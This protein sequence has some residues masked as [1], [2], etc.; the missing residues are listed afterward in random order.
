MSCTQHLFYL[1]DTGEEK[2]KLCLGLGAEKWIDF[3]EAGDKLVE[4][5]KAATD[6]LGAHAAIVTAGK[7]SFSSLPNVQI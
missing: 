1:S 4:R 6:G 7:V 3:K 5:V 2:K